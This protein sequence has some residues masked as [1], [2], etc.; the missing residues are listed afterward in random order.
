MS[1]D[2]RSERKRLMPFLPRIARPWRRKENVAEKLYG[3]IVAQARLPLFYQEFGV[4]D[5][6]EGRYLVL[7]LNLFAVLHRLKGEGTEAA[8]L[9]QELADCFKD[10]METV[11]RELGVSDLRIPKKMRGLAF[12]SAA[13]LQAY[14][15]AL[16]MG[17]GALAETI[18]R[19]LPDEGEAAKAAGTQLA[20]YLTESVRS[21]ER[22]PYAMVRTGTLTFPD[23]S[24]KR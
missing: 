2:G 10:D 15:K 12:S 4:P 24:A 23:L 22:E 8:L 7:S 11:L 21:L 1:L 6:L 17:E 13:L 3:A 5:T 14:G 20:H 9:I 19:A 16:V 18:C